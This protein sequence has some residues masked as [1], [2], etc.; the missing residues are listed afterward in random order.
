MRP[1]SQKPS[2]W[3]PPPS[4]PTGP[5]YS[6]PGTDEGRGVLDD[7]TP[8]P[9]QEAVHADD[10]VGGQDLVPEPGVQQMQHG[11][12]DVQVHPAVPGRRPS[13]PSPPRVPAA[14][15][16][17]RPRPPARGRKSVT[18]TSPAARCPAGRPAGRWS[19]RCRT[20]LRRQLAR[21]AVRGRVRRQARRSSYGHRPP[22]LAVIP[23]A[24][25]LQEDPLRPFVVAG[26]GGLPWSCPRPSRARA[27][28]AG[29]AVDRRAAQVGGHARLSHAAALP[30]PRAKPGHGRRGS[31]PPAES[32]LVKTS[33]NLFLVS[34]WQ[35]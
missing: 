13:P 21:Q 18:G 35:T 20:A 19:S 8:Q 15:P 11:V 24:E 25:D 17:R 4:P 2:G 3:R 12:L 31:L 1:Q 32:S 26:I 16:A 23:A 29:S 10:V 7:G 34:R 22:G 6:R 33:R 27:R 14:A 9:L 30:G 28:R 5:A